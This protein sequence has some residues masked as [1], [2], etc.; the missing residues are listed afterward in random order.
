MM[1]GS[2]PDRLKALR[3]GRRMARVRSITGLD[4]QLQMNRDLWALAASY[5][6]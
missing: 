1:R 2:R 3:E 5:L 4:A 6:N